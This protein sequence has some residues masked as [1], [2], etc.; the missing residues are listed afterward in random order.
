MGKWKFTAPDGTAYV[1]EGDDEEGAYQAFQ[2]KVKQDVQDEYGHLPWYSKAGTAVNDMARIVS[3]AGSFGYADDLAAYMGG[4]DPGKE[5]YETE[6][7]R[8]RAGSAGT[9]AEILPAFALPAFRAKSVLGN[10]GL[11]A[12]EGGVFG[13]SLAGAHGEPIPEGMLTGA[14]TGGGVGAG[15]QL[16]K[17]ALKAA[18]RVIT[19]G[20]VGLAKDLSKL[21]VVHGLQAA[22]ASLGAGMAG[23]PISTGA[24]V[25]GGA[26]VPVVGALARAIANP[27]MRKAVIAATKAAKEEAKKNPPKFFKPGTRQTLTGMGILSERDLNR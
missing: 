7:A 4:T 10:L 25:L 9:A 6:K 16:L 27:K 2:D 11:G 3:N 20:G 26:A 21:N 1:V 5:R 13:G 14:F 19:K 18:P 17:G 15:G 24:A 23:A 12:A 22:G 8:M